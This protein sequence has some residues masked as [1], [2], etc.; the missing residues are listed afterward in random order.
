MTRSEKRGCEER[1]DRSES[2]GGGCKADQATVASMRLVDSVGI[3]V[4]ELI[5]YRLDPVVILTGNKL[6][7][8]SFKPTEVIRNEIVEIEQQLVTRARALGR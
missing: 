4:A 2:N 5:E 8:D 3:L 6:P 1:T 7:N